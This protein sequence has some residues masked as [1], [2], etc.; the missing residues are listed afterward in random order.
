MQVAVS[1]GDGA[2]THN[3]GLFARDTFQ[4]SVNQPGFYRS[5]TDFVTARAEWTLGRGTLTDI[6]GWRHYDLRTRND[7]DSSP[8]KIFESDLLA[9]SRFCF[10]Q[11]MQR[12]EDAVSIANLSEDINLLHFKLDPGRYVRPL[13]SVQGSCLMEWTYH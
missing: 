2:T 12:H 11:H 8:V 5:E 6:A 4:I 3:K 13:K 10:W 9:V 7:I 1:T